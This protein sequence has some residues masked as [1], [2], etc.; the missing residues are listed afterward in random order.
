MA[1]AVCGSACSSGETRAPEA[2]ARVDTNSGQPDAAA[3][4]PPF[5]IFFVDRWGPSRTQTAEVNVF[6]VDTQ[7]SAEQLKA[8]ARAAAEQTFASKKSCFVFVRLHDPKTS[9]TA[10][11]VSAF[12]TARPIPTG[13]CI[14]A[15]PSVWDWEYHVFPK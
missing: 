12:G 4:V 13:A 1:V 10:E 7:P 5:R 3:A 14:S 11:D 2:V 8:V 6:I 9:T 15:D